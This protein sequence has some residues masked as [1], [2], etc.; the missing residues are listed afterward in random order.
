MRSVLAV[1][2]AGVTAIGLASAVVARLYRT[3]PTTRAQQ[4]IAVPAYWTPAVPAG[5][6]MF[7]GLAA[8][9]PAT[10]IVVVNGSRSAP[11]VPRH[12]A[13]SQT[14]R[15]LRD[16]GTLPLGYV[17]TGYF[18]IDFGPG[19]HTT[20]P[21]GAGGGGSHL[22]AWRAQ[23]DRDV[24][25]WYALYG[26]DGLGG[27]FFDQTAALCGPDGAYVE[28][29]RAIVERVRTRYPG[30]YV[31]MNPGR[32]TERCY[33]GIA[34]TLVTFEGSYLEYL[35][36]R[37]APWEHR[38]PAARLWHLV[39]DAPD[40]ASMHRAVTLSKR[41]NAGFVYVTSE[42]LT[43]DGRRHP[44]DRLPDDGYWRAELTAAYGRPV[45]PPAVPVTAAGPR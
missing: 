23:I 10:G 12:P 24:D 3:E 19:A 29:H 43:P 45:V 39:Y 27:I 2:V 9:A 16:G 8:T 44:W 34:D 21:D 41:R 38:V 17:D 22:A 36:H 13:W 30:A 11:E 25:D 32:S 5:R 28:L 35:A 4:R 6:A 31:V 20:R 33:A 15:T 18:G 1:T 40:P 26:S 14:V 42:V 7:D 37:P